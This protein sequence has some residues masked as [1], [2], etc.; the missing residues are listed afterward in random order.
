MNPTSR[1][2]VVPFLVLALALIGAAIRMYHLDYSCLWIDEAWTLYV[3]QGD[4]IVIPFMD[5]HPPLYNWT[6]K[7]A[8]Y[9]IGSFYP[10]SAIRMVP[11]ICGVLAIPLTWR[12]GKELTGYDIPGLIAATLVTF[13]AFELHYSQEARSYTFL[14]CLFLLFCIAYLMAI[15]QDKA[16]YWYITA[17]LSVALVWTHHLMYIPVLFTALHAVLYRKWQVTRPMYFAGGIVLFGWALAVPSFINAIEYRLIEGDTFFY[18]G[19]DLV[20][21][22]LVQFGAGNIIIATLMF[23]MAMVGLYF[24]VQQCEGPG[25]WAIIVMAGY[26]SACVVLSYIIMMFPKYL[27]ILLPIYCIAIGFGIFRVWAELRSRLRNDA[28]VDALV[29]VFLFGLVALCMQPV[30]AHHQ[31]MQTESWT[32]HDQFMQNLLG[33]GDK[34]AILANPGY[35]TM[36]WYYAPSVGGQ[37]NVTVFHSLADLESVQDGTAGNLWVFVPSAD[38]K[39]SELEEAQEIMAYL[40]ESGEYSGEYKVWEYYRIGDW[41]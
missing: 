26:T 34:A 16:K 33:D 2:V 28:I 3:S 24:L 31:T 9:L 4:W 19:L 6:T 18:I 30:I 38:A 13:S 41:K 8:L 39:G 29:A 20:T 40:N 36:F 32:G 11:F 27:L 17:V 21:A 37:E 1:N 7:I 22:T 10:E 5:V 25:G 23:I 35:Y 12:L 14:L 15:R